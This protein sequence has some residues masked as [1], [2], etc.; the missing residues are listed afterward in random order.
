V[1]APWIADLSFGHDSV[2]GA[3]LKARGC[4][5]VIGY[6]GCD[7]NGKNA[8]KANVAD[9]LASG[10]LVG[11]VIENG[12]QDVLGG[13]AAGHYL[14]TNVMTGAKA[15]GYDTAN[16]VLY[17]AADW[18]T[19]AGQEPAV[20]AALAAFA[21]HVPHP[22]LYGNS[23]AI[24]YVIGHGHAQYG[25]QSNSTSFS[26]GPS[27]H[28][29]LLQRYNDPRAAGLPV[30]VND[31]QH[32]PFGLMGED[33]PLAPA[34]IE[35]IAAAV[36]NHVIGAGPKVYDTAG[37]MVIKLSNSLND[38]PTNT[39]LGAAL[40][41]LPKPPATAEI[42]AAIK[43][44]PPSGVTLTDAQIQQL[45]ATIAQATAA[46]NFTVTLTGD[47]KPATPATGA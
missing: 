19:T 1:T 23:Y 24:D 3:V 34:E 9:W 31:I 26:Y 38:V 35:A 10:L 16:C 8:T 46:P 44:D 4:V 14:G 20:D 6:A 15:V 45:A 18:N 39:E 37:H 43:A 27:P 41:G 30:D 11:L 42:A 29:Q 2:K 22:G 32:T 33:M 12:A 7:D 17:V 25:W 21:S 28:A 5:G 36:W 13:A 47:A 40:S